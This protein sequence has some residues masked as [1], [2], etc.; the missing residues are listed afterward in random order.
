[1]HEV[2]LVLELITP[3][4]FTY[5]HGKYSRRQVSSPQ[6][7]VLMYRFQSYLF[8]ELFVSGN[9]KFKEDK[10]EM[11][12]CFD[13]WRVVKTFQLIKL[14]ILLKFNPFHTIVLFLYPLKT[15]GNQRFFNVSKGYRKR[16]MAWNGLIVSFNFLIWYFF[17]RT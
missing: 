7:N 14:V 16:P 12:L 6:H 4:S 13:K 2:L 9:L 1:M 5:N 8:S 10:I 11:T 17:K 3:E 15:S